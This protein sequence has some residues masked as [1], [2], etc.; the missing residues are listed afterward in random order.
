M[1]IQ[2]EQFAIQRVKLAQML[3]FAREPLPAGPFC[4]MGPIGKF[5]Q[6]AQE[7]LGVGGGAG[8]CDLHPGRI[9]GNSH[10]VCFVTGSGLSVPSFPVCIQ[11]ALEKSSVRRIVGSWSASCPTIQ[12]CFDVVS[13]RTIGYTQENFA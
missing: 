4:K 1:D 11:W 13:R 9:D 12:T 7:R 6:R 8:L 5:A 3:L 10:L 2:P